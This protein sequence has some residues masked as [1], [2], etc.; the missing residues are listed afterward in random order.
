VS[1]L[2]EPMKT[3]PNPLPARR[4]L[5]LQFGPAMPDGSLSFQGRVEH[6]ASGRAECFSSEQELRK[7]LVELLSQA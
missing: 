1:K 3:A 6:I 5:V 4:A 7:V 2:N